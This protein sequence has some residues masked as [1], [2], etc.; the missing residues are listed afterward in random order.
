MSIRLKI[1]RKV[2]TTYKGERNY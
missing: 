2:K 1:T